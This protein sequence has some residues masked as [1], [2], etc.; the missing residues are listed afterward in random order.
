[1]TNIEM[2][3]LAIN[4]PAF[5]QA[6]KNASI[7]GCAREWLTER[8]PKDKAEKALFAAILRAYPEDA[9]TKETCDCGD[10]DCDECPTIAQ[11]ESMVRQCEIE[12][13]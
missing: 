2:D 13:Q 5:E 9:N 4:S 12:S 11:V 3:G 10:D 7:A 8:E 6:Q 1:M